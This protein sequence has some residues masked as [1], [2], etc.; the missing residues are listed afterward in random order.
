[1]LRRLSV[2]AIALVI[3]DSYAVPASSPAFANEVADGPVEPGTRPPVRMAPICTLE[4]RLFE[5]EVWAKVVSR[6]CVNCHVEGGEAAESEL[7]L[8]NASSAAADAGT[9]RQNRL[10][11]SELARR[12]D[13]RSGG[14]LLLAKVV[15]EL[16]HGG[17]EVVTRGSPEYE[18]LKRF[19]ARVGSSTPPADLQLS[20]I[21]SPPFFEDVTMLTPRRHLR[22]LT[23]SLVGRLPTD[24][25][26]AA[27]DVGGTAAIEDL[28]DAM[29]REDAFYTRL[30]EAF[31]DIFL[32]L[33]VEDN[34]ETLLSY[35]HFEKTRLWTQKHDV[36]DLPKAEQDR[37][38]WKLADVY[39]EALLREP[40]ELIAYIVRNERPFTEIVTADYFMASP[41]TA[42]G[43]GIFDR[44]KGEFSNPD[45]PFEYIPAKLDALRNRAGKVQESPTGLYPHAGV[46]GSFHYLKRYPTTETNRNRARSRMLYEHF[47]G[48]D[49]MQLAPRT[50]DA[51]AVA[52][53]FEV[54]V[55]EAADCVVCHRTID[56]VAGLF[57]DFDENGYLARP[58]DGWHQDMFPPGFE[59]E[60]LPA[61]ER[62]RALQWLGERT[63]Q[64]PRF[65]VAMTEHVYYMLMGRKV[66]QPPLDIQDP[67][68]RHSLR[69]Y[70]EQRRMIAAVAE[71]LAAS[72]YNLKEAIKA[73]AMTDFYRAD[74][75]S[76]ELQDPGRRAEL[77]D[78]GVVRL[79]APE[80][81]E[82]KIAAIFGEPWGRLD[83]D[84]RILYGGIDSRTVTERNTD[85]GGAMGAIQRLLANDV[86]C[87]HVAKDFHRMAAERRLFPSIEPDVVPG[88]PA[89][90]AAIRGAVAHLHSL[91]LGVDAEPTD[92]EV[93]RTFDLFCGILDDAQAAGDFSENE[94]YHCGG[95]DEFDTPDPH[96]TIRAWR[97]VVTYL[98]LQPEFLYE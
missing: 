31:N 90:D 70:R 73:I 49:V 52:A 37:A 13:D 94:T 78:V 7:L 35:D 63:A 30:K 74:G 3:L 50:S 56:P 20:D 1:M 43:Y 11:V 77:A 5:E 4:D 88:E 87:E 34:A 24:A 18:V 75:L 62:W 65:A 66:L 68:F 33:G 96:Y 97:G 98:L 25:E 19:V 79:L 64:D 48:I 28:M 58:K 41:Y 32:T 46:L 6:V 12:V 55:M 54:P 38:R 23:L 29:M 72:D 93:E 51:A 80:Q 9:M 83:G 26:L 16:D 15:G 47:L 76:A 95:R 60:D 59:G 82:R 21:D 89:S 53:E 2:L 45:D 84:M 8:S 14:S 27:V 57:Q 42:R 67:H 22:R 71:R 85:P 39:R 10:A 91:L 92:P 81:L 61:S 40:L 44:I 86:A 69:A 17:G 36:G